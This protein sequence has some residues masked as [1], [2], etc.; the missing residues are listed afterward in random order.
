MRTTAF[1]SAS[2]T[3]AT[4]VAWVDTAKGLCIILVVMMHSTLGLG[5][6]VGREGW[7]HTVVAFAKPFRMPDFFLV[8]G[9]F[10]GRVI[11]RDWRS[12]GDRR[13]VHFLYFYL[14][15]F[16]IQF[17]FKGWGLAGGDPAE[18]LRQFALGF[19]EPLGT[20]WF[21]YLLAIF[22]VATKLLRRVPPFALLG[23]AAALQTMPVHTGWTVVDEF[24]ARYVYFLV[25][26]LLAPAIFAFAARVA[27]R[28]LATLAGLAAWALANG[29]LALTPAGLTGYPTLASLPL[30]SLALGLA[31]A[32]AIVAAASLLARTALAR[33]FRYCGEHSIAIYL[34]FFLPMALTRVALVKLG[35]VGDVG[36]ASA[37]ITTV[38]VVVPLVLERLVQDTR[39]SFLFTRPAA[40]RLMPVSRLAPAA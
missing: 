13:V 21:V 10:L 18:L 2:A 11:D 30:V 9:L 25:G 27:T 26:Y 28:P 12:Y 22:S 40:F 35:L 8:S 24:A 37:F 3:D 20:L 32:G 34:A 39:L 4:R 38:A 6:A 29:I 15:W 36:W 14:L 23:L 31:G 33:P 19:V 1:D 16:L 7:L 17:A 5:E